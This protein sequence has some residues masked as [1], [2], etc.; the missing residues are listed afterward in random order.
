MIACICNC[1]T[2]TPVMTNRHG[3][4]IDR[5][6]TWSSSCAFLLRRSVS[7]FS[8][9]FLPRS[10][11]SW[12]SYYETTRRCSKKTI[13]QVNVMF[14]MEMLPILEGSQRAYDNKLLEQEDCL[15]NPDISS[16]V[17]LL[18]AQGFHILFSSWSARF[19]KPTTITKQRSRHCISI[20]KSDIPLKLLDL[21]TREHVKHWG[22]Y[23]A[24][25]EEINI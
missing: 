6:L 21:T 3:K 2:K 18:H 1:E 14:T 17:S 9:S 11:S 19:P 12:L 13:S 7:S 24:I 22:G 20:L 16:V 4:E 25:K 5:A 10:S 23:T 8:C 15:P